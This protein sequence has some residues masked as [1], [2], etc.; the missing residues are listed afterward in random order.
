MHARTQIRQLSPLQ[1]LMSWL[2][3]KLLPT[4][5]RPG[6]SRRPS[7]AARNRWVAS[8]LKNCQQLVPQADAMVR[9][10]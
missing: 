7:V 6:R 1:A 9:C 2:D 5:P 10:A 8:L 3:S 4:T